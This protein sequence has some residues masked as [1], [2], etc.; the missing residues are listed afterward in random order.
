MLLICL[1]NCTSNNQLILNPT[2]LGPLKLSTDRLISPQEIQT[3]FP[4]FIVSHKIA[5]GDSPDFHLI[6]IQNAKQEELFYI[7][8]YFNETVDKD[9]PKYAIDL[10]VISSS[11]IM[12]AYGIRVGDDV[13]KVISQRGS[14]L[15]ISD[16]HHSN[17]IGQNLIH[18]QVGS[19]IIKELT[20][21][22]HTYTRPAGIT[23]DKI[24]ST[25][26]VVTSISW[27]QPSWD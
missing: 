13:Q 4:D 7:I 20:Q 8:S 27:P 2:H 22:D 17:S 23:K 21:K 14:N 24:I 16:N 1:S 3:L 12:D 25:N 19:P 6:N 5:S 18:Y 9:T 11:K 26:P 15:A 10:L